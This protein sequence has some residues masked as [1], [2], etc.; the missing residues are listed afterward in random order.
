MIDSKKIPVIQDEVINLARASILVQR[1]VNTGDVLE[2]DVRES[3]PGNST[4]NY[5]RVRID[6]LTGRARIEQP[7]IQ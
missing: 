4:N 2:F 5:N 6:G 7:Q 1:D 3:P